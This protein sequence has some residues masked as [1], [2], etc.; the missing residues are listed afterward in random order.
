MGY[1]ENKNTSAYSLNLFH[2]YRNNK[3]IK[4][5]LEKVSYLKNDW[6]ESQVE[7]YIKTGSKSLDPTSFIKQSYYKFGKVG[8][9]FGGRD[10]FTFS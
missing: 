6:M 2:K 8:G 7:Y 3:K 1:T 9:G 4:P 10:D 5:V